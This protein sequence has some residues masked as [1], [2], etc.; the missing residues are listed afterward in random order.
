MCQPIGGGLK[1]FLEFSYGF[2]AEF[3]AFFCLNGKAIEVTLLNHPFETDYQD[4]QNIGSK[5]SHEV[6]RKL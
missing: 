3:L 5:N 2:L 6:S 4:A 1:E